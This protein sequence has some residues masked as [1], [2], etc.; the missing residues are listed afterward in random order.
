MKRYINIQMLS[1]LKEGLRGN[2]QEEGSYGEDV[3]WGLS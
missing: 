1:L 2:A 3:V